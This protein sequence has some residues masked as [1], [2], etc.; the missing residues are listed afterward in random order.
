[1]I[2]VFVIDNFPGI[3]S[4]SMGMSVIDLDYGQPIAKSDQV[5]KQFMSQIKVPTFPSTNKSKYVLPLKHFLFPELLFLSGLT[6]QQA[7]NFIDIDTRDEVQ[8]TYEFLAALNCDNV[9]TH[10][11]DAPKMLNAKH[12]KKGKLPF[13]SYWVL[14]IDPFHKKQSVLP[15]LGGTHS[16]PRTH[17]RRGH[18][19]RMSNKRIWIN[20]V[21]VTAGSKNG[22]VHKDYSVKI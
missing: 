19:R 15:H 11:I 7:L 4:V 6:A 12:K 20:A 5:Y 3:W 13:D 18:I 8:A 17:L 2:A 9:G 16:S 14:D 1:M 22:C 21:L 10:K